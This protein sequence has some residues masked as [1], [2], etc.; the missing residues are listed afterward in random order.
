MSREPGR[1]GERGSLK[2][3]VA[4]IATIVV[5]DIG[6]GLTYPL[7]NIILESRHI[8][9]TVIGLNAAMGPL[10]IILSGPFIPRLVARFGGR[11]L[12]L[13]AMIA[14]ILVL[15]SFPLFPSIGVWFATRFLFGVAGSTLYTLSEAWILGFAP[16]DARGRVA[17]I[18]GSAL[19]LG[20]SV[21]PF[22]LPYTG[23]EG[24]LPFV[25][26]A[27]L[28]ALSALPLFFIDLDYT[29]LESAGSTT[30]LGFV[31]R[32]PLLLF[33]VATLT[34]FDAVM[35]AFFPIFGLRSGLDLKTA[36]WA[37]AVAIAG[38]AVLQYP[39]GWLA[40]RW[41]RQGVL[42]IAAI[43]TPLLAMSL[44]FVVTTPLLWPV[45]LLLGTSAYAVY[46]IA[47]TVMADRFQGTDLVAGS[48]AFGAMWGVGGIVGP[49]VAGIAL[50]LLGPPG[51]AVT[52]TA[53]YVGLI[54]GLLLARGELVRQ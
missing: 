19:S 5:A 1:A 29:G 6:F 50:D 8:D 43:A 4:A 51:I 9:A 38:N 15:L 54:A 26:A 42:W 41:S 32:A 27:L 53:I 45:A 14:I 30:M 23:V 7:L 22:L 16:P 49:P 34:M 52:L 40:D 18:Y 35:L 11:R 31:R 28:V 10:G 37:L 44:P 39:I 25:L 12:A 46:I 20:F 3:L 24:W 21:G 47:M 17:A 36:S 2:N 33:A 13:A 48:A